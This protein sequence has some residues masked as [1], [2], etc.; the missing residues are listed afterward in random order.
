M[1]AAPGRTPSLHFFGGLRGLGSPNWE[2][3]EGLA[4]TVRIATASTMEEA[5]A[6][7]TQRGVTHIILPSWDTELDTLAGWTSVNPNDTFLGALRRW[8]LPPWLQ[9]LPYRLP[10][11]TGLEGQSVV[12]LQVTENTDRALALSRLADYALE[13]QDLALADAVNDSLQAFPANLSALIARAEIEKVRERPEGVA[14]ALEPLLQTLTNGLDRVLPWDRRMSL[15]VVLAQADRRDLAT[16]QLRR[17]LAEAN[18]ER[19]RSLGA[20]SIYR[21][22]VLSK[23][24]AVPLPEKL[25][26]YALTLLPAEARARL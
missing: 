11:I 22:L 13:V 12:V 24:F 10:E 2:N 9:P 15:A 16:T 7:L 25:R 23:A 17:C 18:E 26:D 8:A 14:R 6:L 20:G 4:A 1:L 3:P 19:L 21:L 5:Q